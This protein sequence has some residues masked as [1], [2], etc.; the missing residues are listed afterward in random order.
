MTLDELNTSRNTMRQTTTER[1][2]SL[3][4][5]KLFEYD[6]RQILK[7]SQEVDRI[8]RQLE[9]DTR[10]VTDNRDLSTEGS[11][12]QLNELVESAKSAVYVQ[13]DIVQGYYESA[14]ESYE[15]QTSLS[16]DT[17][18]VLLADASTRLH[19]L[20]RGEKYLGE[21]SFIDIYKN[22]VDDGDKALSE[23]VKMNYRSLVRQY[24]GQAA[25]HPEWIVEAAMSEKEVKR[26][27]N[28]L[29]V[30]DCAVN[31]RQAA[32]YQLR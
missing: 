19:F 11:T 14:V 12:R 5:P 2:Q 22:A 23:W 30:M 3:D 15:G 16:P 1:L 27:R 31:I 18:D 17:S 8:L 6:H 32:M 4:V 25:K 28:A 7:A 20:V 9:K 10:R 13:A 21:H 29:K 26:H 24:T